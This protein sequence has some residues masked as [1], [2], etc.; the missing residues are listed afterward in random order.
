[1]FPFY[2]TCIFWQADS[3][4]HIVDGFMQNMPIPMNNRNGTSNIK[5]EHTLFHVYKVNQFNNYPKIILNAVNSGCQVNI[6]SLRLC[7]TFM[8]FLTTL[9]LIGIYSGNRHFNGFPGYVL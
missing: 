2:T 7:N 8:S 1:M 9:I 3:F 6:Y 4:D 5:A